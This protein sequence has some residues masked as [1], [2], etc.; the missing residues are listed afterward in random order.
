MLHHRAG[1]VQHRGVLLR[2][3]WLQLRQPVRFLTLS[4]FVIRC[5]KI[6]LSASNYLS[7]ELHVCDGGA[8][9]G[10]A[11]IPAALEEASQDGAA[12]TLATLATSHQTVV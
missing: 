5:I 8:V 4:G 3:G 12:E 6:Y 11:R 7:Q 10:G 9:L 2:W 1:G